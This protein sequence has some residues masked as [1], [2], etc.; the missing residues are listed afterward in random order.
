MVMIVFV[1][2]LGSILA[3]AVVHDTGCSELGDS[4]V[5]ALADQAETVDSVS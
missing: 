4:D 5:Q 2:A 3:H 1:C